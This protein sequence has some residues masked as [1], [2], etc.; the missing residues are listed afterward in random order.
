MQALTDTDF[1]DNALVL[2]HLRLLVFQRRKASML[3]YLHFDYTALRNGLAR[4]EQRG[5]MVLALLRDV[6]FI[7]KRGRVIETA[8]L[9]SLYLAQAARAPSKCSALSVQMI[10]F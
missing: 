8:E 7:I 10:A 4:Y 9:T 5:N 2:E 1:W 3:Q 6:K